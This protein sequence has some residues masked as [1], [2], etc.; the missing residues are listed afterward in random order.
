MTR[1]A[2]TIAVVALIGNT[3]AR[4]PE[5]LA[6]QRRERARVRSEKGIRWGGQRLTPAA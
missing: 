3:N 5:A 4:H 2:I 6:A 1:R